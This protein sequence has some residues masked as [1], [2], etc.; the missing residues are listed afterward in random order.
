MITVALID[1]HTIVR[2]GFAQ[3]LNLEQDIM[4]QGEY[5]S[6][7][8]AFHALIG[9]PVDVAI[10]DIS[11]PDENGLNLLERLHQHNPNF[12]AIPVII[13]DA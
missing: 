7:K 9:S 12:K 4:V 3:L 10:I 2:S 8:E 6:A 13:E 1:D 11:M 5:E